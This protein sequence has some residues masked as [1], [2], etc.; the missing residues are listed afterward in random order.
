MT[1]HTSDETLGGGQEQRGTDSESATK[2]PNADR[3]VVQDSPGSPDL[4]FAPDNGGQGNLTGAEIDAPER[5]VPQDTGD[6]DQ[7][8][9]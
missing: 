9:D 1:G 5:E 4:G 6:E 2:S 3:G 8:G 7:R